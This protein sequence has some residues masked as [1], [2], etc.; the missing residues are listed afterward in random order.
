MNQDIRIG[1]FVCDCG[2]TLSN[3]D[4]PG[5]VSR[6]ERVSDIGYVG[7]CHYLCSSDELEQIGFEIKHSK[8]NRVVIGACSPQFSESLFMKTLQQAGLDPSLLCMANIREQCSWVHPNAKKAT[9]KAVRQIKMAIRRARVLEPT[10][11]EEI[12]LN[13]DVL[14]VGGGISGMQAA[15]E[16]SKLGHRVTL[17]EKKRF[18]GG[19]LHRLYSLEPLQ[20]RPEDL[21]AEKTA[22]I[23]KQENTEV[24][25][26][27]ELMNMEGQ[28]GNFTA[29]IQLDSAPIMRRFGG[30][31]VATGCDAK[32]FKD[33]YGVELSGNIVSQFQFEEMLRTKRSWEMGPRRI[34]FMLDLSDEYQRISSIAALRDGLAVKKRF[35]SEVY[36]FCKHMK[37]DA[38][39]VAEMYRDAR[40]KGIIF[41]K[42]GDWRPGISQANGQ[43]SIELEDLYLAKEPIRVSCDLLV[44]DERIIPRE[45]SQSLASTLGID[46]D[47]RGFYQQPNVH[48]Y[49]VNSNRKGI[50]FA[51]TCHA[52]LDVGEELE[53]GCGAAQ[54]LHHLLSWDNAWIEGSTAVVDPDRCV[55]CLTCIRTCPHHAVE[56][57]GESHTAKVIGAACRGC[58]LC[59]A[60][61]PAK[62]IT[63]KGC[64]GDEITAQLDVFGEAIND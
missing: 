57:D 39:G 26:S 48:L 49:P 50:V 51:G 4:F 43:V 54:H 14:V 8:L 17:L 36:V 56:V 19:R 23:N 18:L 22:G 41:F 21:L 53:D 2:K 55:L 52:D 5:I 32:Y 45:D 38:D 63:L 42:F 62:A 28:V 40:D 58:G 35:G 37:L 29:T 15:L 9:S 7:H 47:S 12:S 30:I 1:V 10:E 13:R 64:T 60:E 33:R 61:C 44:V 24:L 20:T 3:I 6:L 16:L 46:C 25:T 31:V 34:G 59:A 11:K 27:S